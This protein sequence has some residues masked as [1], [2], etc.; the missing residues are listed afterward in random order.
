MVNLNPMQKAFREVD[1]CAEH[2]ALLHGLIRDARERSWSIFVVFLDLAKAFDI[3][4]HEL[5]TMALRRL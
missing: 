3:V 2:I 4:H 1:G 5:V